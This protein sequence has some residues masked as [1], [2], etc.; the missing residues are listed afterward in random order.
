MRVGWRLTTADG[1]REVGGGIEVAFARRS[2]AGALARFYEGHQT[3]SRHPQHGPLGPVCLTWFVASKTLNAQ[4]GGAL[5]AYVIRSM[6]TTPYAEAHAHALRGASTDGLE[7]N[8]HYAI[9]VLPGVALVRHEVSGHFNPG[10]ASRFGTDSL[11][12]VAV[13]GAGSYIIHS[14]VLSVAP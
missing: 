14:W 10:G 5:V 3:A 2:L 12:L 7:V 11:S 9:P 4:I 6:P 1:A 13:Y 8:V